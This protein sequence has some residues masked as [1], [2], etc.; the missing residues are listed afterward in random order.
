[1]VRLYGLHAVAAALANPLRRPLR[2]HATPRAMA[3][4]ERRVPI[5]DGLAVDLVAGTTLKAL[6]PAGAVTQGALLDAAPLPPRG[7]DAAAPDAAARS[8][9][10]VLDQVT[11]PM[12]VGAVLRSAA[13]FGARALITQERH[14]PAESGALAKAAA[15][16][17][18]LVPWIRVPNLARALDRLAGMGYWRIGLAA[19]A[20]APLA[21]A[22]RGTD[23]VALVLGAEG[24]G[25]R[26]LS[27]RHCD[28]LAAIPIA[29]ARPL[30]DS[31][32]VSNAAAV[33]LYELASRGA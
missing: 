21:E 1:M 12:N 14:S 6:A 15:G 32:N 16:A 10:V 11:D 17:L 22:K 26:P 24:R 29:P 30:I 2:L 27:E 8:L 20:A 18:D 19:G 31:L 28:Q 23:A 33:A 5:P 4:L 7:L 25:L 13:A 9:V 3:A